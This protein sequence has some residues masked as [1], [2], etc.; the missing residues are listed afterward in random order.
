M[1]IPLE[2]GD[3][4]ELGV[5]Y[6]SQIET[7]IQ[8]N[9]AVSGCHTAEGAGTGN[10]S[11]YAGIKAK[12]VNGSFKERVIEEMSMPPSYTG[13]ELSNMELQQLVCWLQAGAPEN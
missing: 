9:C 3:C 8:L 5:Q 13:N 12:V 6:Y 10:F 2:V 11:T 7:I 4:V 1:P